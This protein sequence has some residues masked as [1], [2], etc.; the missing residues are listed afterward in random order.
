MRRSFDRLSSMVKES[1]RREVPSG[2]L[3]VFFNR[4]RD[5]VKLLY[6]DD[7]GLAL[8]YKRLETGVFRVKENVEGY[9]EITGVDLEL[10][11]GGM[12]LSRLRMRNSFKKGIYKRVS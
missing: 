9:E 2:G 6:W 3:Y 12:D 11:L 1:L 10:L 7:D 4:A 5:K 8:W